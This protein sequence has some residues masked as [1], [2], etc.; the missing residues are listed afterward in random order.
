MTRRLHLF[1]DRGRST[2]PTTSTRLTSGSLDAS[3]PELS[4]VGREAIS[5]CVIC[6]ICERDYQWTGQTE[7]YTCQIGAQYACCPPDT[8]RSVDVASLGRCTKASGDEEDEDEKEMNAHEVMTNESIDE[9]GDEFDDMDEEES[10]S[11]ADIMGQEDMA[12]RECPRPTG[13]QLKPTGCR[14]WAR[15]VFPGGNVVIG[16]VAAET[17]WMLMNL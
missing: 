11:S 1:V 4:L 14:S 10:E 12:G 3:P 13:G 7:P 6:D 17:K 5:R 2:P 15:A 16:V 8:G 9:E